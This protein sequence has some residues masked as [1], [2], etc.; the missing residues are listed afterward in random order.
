MFIE[1]II[2][3]ATKENQ[4]YGTEEIKVENLK[5]YVVSNNFKTGNENN[6]NVWR[7]NT[8]IA[9]QEIFGAWTQSQN[10]DTSV[11]EDEEEEGP[12]L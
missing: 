8:G 2:M 5:T 1:P 11:I 4:D 3:K 12:G 9:K 7:A 10:D 6:M